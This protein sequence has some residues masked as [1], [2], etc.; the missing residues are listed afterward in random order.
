[1]IATHI[2]KLINSRLKQP[3]LCVP[4]VGPVPAGLLYSGSVQMR[5]KYW[6]APSNAAQMRAAREMVASLM[7]RLPEY[8]VPALQ[9]GRAK[10]IL[11][12]RDWRADDYVAVTPVSHA[13]VL[14]E[15]HCRLNDENLPYMNWMV[16]PNTAA[17][18][19]HSELLLEQRG[20][21]RLLQCPVMPPA[22]SDWR[23]DFVQ[24][25]FR[26]ESANLSGGYMAAGWPAVSAVGGF[27]HVLERAT[28]QNIDFAIGLRSA[29]MNMGVRKTVN[30]RG[31][32]PK[33]DF[34]VEEVTGHIDVVLLL[35]GHDLDVIARTL[36][37]PMAPRRFAGGS[38]HIFDVAVRENARAPAA[39]YLHRLAVDE[40][41][42][43]SAACR[44]IA[45]SG[46]WEVSRNGRS[47]K[48]NR[49]M[50]MLTQ[51]GY[52]LLSQPEQNQHARGGYLHAWGEQV[53]AIVQQGPMAESAWW[54]QW[55]DGEFVGYDGC[56]PV[57]VS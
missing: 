5:R 19:N 36:A 12:P 20:R 56:A 1:M 10:Q 55:S 53:H 57:A 49:G 14:H 4:D 2:P 30:D 3:A 47:F 25:T 37:A 9:D 43:M 33:P 35:D 45:S 21:L 27:V 29:Q 6:A 52:V 48:P 50:V 51:V 13:G 44:E 32:D 42:V 38:V 16:Q 40:H 17:W 8:S 41:D 22:E 31:P 7:G 23:G 46:A 11:L 18:S 54:R 34:V 24:V 26:A 28:G 39:T 15:W